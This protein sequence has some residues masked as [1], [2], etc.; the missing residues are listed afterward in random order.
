MNTNIPNLPHTR[1]L[2][3]KQ[4]HNG[5]KLP[6]KIAIL[7]TDA[8]REYCSTD[9]E[10]QTIDG[11]YEEALLF[12]PYFQKLGVATCYIQADVHMTAKLRKENP[13]WRS[14]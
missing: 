8:K 4:N 13:T 9:E 3:A 11:S 12:E 6:K 14:T 10:F 5:G 7:Y 1:P 2:I